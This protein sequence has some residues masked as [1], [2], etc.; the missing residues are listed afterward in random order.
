MKHLALAILAGAT[1]ACAVVAH[2]KDQDTYAARE[3][4]HL[5]DVDNGDVRLSE[6]TVERMTSTRPA[7]LAGLL[8]VEFDLVSTARYRLPFE[9]RLRWFDDAGAE[10]HGPDHWRPTTLEVRETRPVT[11]VAPVPTATGW[12]V[13]LRSRHESN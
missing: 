10:L 13:A 8:R 11:V 1:A 3:G 2:D 12:E 7:D 4:Q 9:W 5:V 6:V